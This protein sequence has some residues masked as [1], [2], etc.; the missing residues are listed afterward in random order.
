MINV[1][2]AV[3]R[4][5]PIAKSQVVA[6]DP[7]ASGLALHEGKDGSG[8]GLWECTPGSFDWEYEMHESVCVLSGEAS[9]QVK[10]G[11]Q[12]A[13]SAGAAA[14]FP[15]GTRA[16]WTVHATLRKVYTLYE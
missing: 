14:F 3:L 8:F 2:T 15:K 7:R 10:G 13:L 12:L 1:E 5:W 4:P 6:G 11:E 16:R 9:V